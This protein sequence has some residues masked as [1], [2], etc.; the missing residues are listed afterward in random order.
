MNKIYCLTAIFI[1]SFSVIAGAQEQPAYRDASRP[2]D[3][4][5]QNLIAAL[6]L[7]EKVQQMMDESPAIPRLNIPA[8]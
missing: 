6:T 5:V 4:R 3:E 2:L 1:F 7:E 8:Y